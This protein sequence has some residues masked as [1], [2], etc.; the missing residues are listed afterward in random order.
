MSH[1]QPEPVNPETIRL[2]LLRLAG[3]IQAMDRDGR[4][5]E[6]A[7]RLLKWMGDLRSQLFEYEVRHTRRLLPKPASSEAE[8]RTAAERESQRI[9]N[10]SLERQRDVEEEWRRGWTS[11]DGA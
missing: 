3:F 1:P 2:H 11:D 10:E 7:P 4:L 6:A 9:V 5:L 8:D